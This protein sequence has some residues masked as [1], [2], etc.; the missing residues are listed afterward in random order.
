MTRGTKIRFGIIFI[1]SVII[2]ESLVKK[3]GVGMGGFLLLSLVFAIIMLLVFLYMR[4]KDLQKQV[5]K[6][7]MTYFRGDMDCDKY[8]EDIKQKM[9]ENEDYNIENVGNINIAAV[10][11][12]RQDYEGALDI[13]SE[14]EYDDLKDV[15]KAL[16]WTHYATAKFYLGEYDDAATIVE[17][18]E[19][20]IYR[21]KNAREGEMLGP[22]FDVAIIFMHW[23]NGDDELTEELYDNA[24]EKWTAKGL[25][26]EVERLGKVIFED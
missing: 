6:Y 18:N 4:G 25:N 20:I 16:Y 17:A 8:L 1:A 14:I 15:N 19:D 5:Q 11:N 26:L 3:M 10:R 13:L 21:F 22:V 23:V 12:F 2:F 9:A 7:T 24:L